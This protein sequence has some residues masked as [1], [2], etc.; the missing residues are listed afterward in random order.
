[1]QTLRDKLD[2]ATATADEHL[3]RASDAEAQL[4]AALE[5]MLRTTRAGPD[6]QVCGGAVG[7]MGWRWG[8]HGGAGGWGGGIAKEAMA[9]LKGPAM[10]DQRPDD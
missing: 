10:P 3:R 5:Q 2:A 6:L 7:P 1:M 9:P 4:D 8:R